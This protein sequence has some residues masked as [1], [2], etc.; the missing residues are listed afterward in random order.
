M[1][2]TG[3]VS[4][5]PSTVVADLGGRQKYYPLTTGGLVP[6]PFGNLGSAPDMT[7]MQFFVGNFYQFE[8]SREDQYFP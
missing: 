2:N 3:F 8:R 7:D 1:T 5:L 4:P 6:P